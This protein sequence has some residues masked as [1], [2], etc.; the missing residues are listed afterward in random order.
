MDHY[1]QIVLDALLASGSLTLAVLFLLFLFGAAMQFVSSFFRNSLT[2]VFGMTFTAWLTAPGVM[3]HEAFHALACLIFGH[4]VK[5]VVFFSPQK[6]GSLGYV[7]HAYDPAS[8]R[9]RLGHF[10]I[11]TAPLWGGYAAIFG[12]TLLLV[13]A[14][15]L[16]GGL[17]NFISLWWM[18][19]QTFQWQLCLWVYLI[20]MI[21][22]QITLSRSDLE[23]ARL[24]VP[25]LFVLMFLAALGVYF[26]KP[27]KN[28]QKEV[29]RIAE[30]QAGVLLYVLSVL[31]FF[32]LILKLCGAG[33]KK[34]NTA[35]RQK[36]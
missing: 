14:E 19:F 2:G 25:L 30:F 20:L 29:L 4:K 18:W 10:F 12:L 22:S 6:N 35:K 13:P 15:Y 32:A 7:D 27:E 31:V 26:W 36:K 5:K 3:L 1:L 23:G 34:R 28:W 17:R 24:G 8:P 11:G 33:N 16:P 9:Q 21:G